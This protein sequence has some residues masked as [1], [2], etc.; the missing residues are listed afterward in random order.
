M[1]EN[2][3][4]SSTSESEIS[5]CSSNFNPL[6]VLYSN[7][8]QVPV[9]NA[10]MYENIQQFE[11][12]QSNS[13]IIPVGQRN[14]VLKREEEKRRKKLEEEKALEEKNKQRFAQYRGNFLRLCLHL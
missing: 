11:A 6:K 4:D 12:A 1:S 3:S 9:K 13:N 2:K 7:K 8:V 10:P 14:A 5:E